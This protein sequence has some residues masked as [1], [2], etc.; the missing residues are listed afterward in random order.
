VTQRI[1]LCP[2]TEFDGLCLL[3]EH[4]IDGGRQFSEWLGDLGLAVFLDR[5]LE[6][7]FAERPCSLSIDCI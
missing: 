2:Y 3:V 7:P 5:V 4:A 6:Q 1:R